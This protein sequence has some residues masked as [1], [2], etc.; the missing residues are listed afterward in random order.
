MR[1]NYVIGIEIRRQENLHL[2]SHSITTLAETRGI[3]ASRDTRTIM[4]NAS[5][6]D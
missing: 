3:A 5:K 4:G 6:P 1:N 2:S